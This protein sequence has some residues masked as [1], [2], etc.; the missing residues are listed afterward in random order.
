[1]TTYTVPEQLDTQL[2]RHGV[3]ATGPL[4]ALAGEDRDFFDDDGLR[5][6]LDAVHANVTH[7]AMSPRMQ[8]HALVAA[9]KP[10]AEIL[11]RTRAD[12][13]GVYDWEVAAILYGYTD[14]VQKDKDV[15]PHWWA[16][17]DPQ[18]YIVGYDAAAPIMPLVRRMALYRFDGDETDVDWLRCAP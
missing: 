10:L 4:A 11:A 3:H 16:H 6:R 5:D 2:S 13:D 7:A 9:V 17:S 18:S 1:M 14:H 15:L 12:I 8:M